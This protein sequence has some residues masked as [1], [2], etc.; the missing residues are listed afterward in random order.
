VKYGY[1]VAIFHDTCE[2]IPFLYFQDTCE[3]STDNS[4]W[5]FLYRKPIGR[6]I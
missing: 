3:I 6:S 1:Q 5:F 4:I 2:D